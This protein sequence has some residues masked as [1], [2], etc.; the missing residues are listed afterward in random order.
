[1]SSERLRVEL[2]T[3]QHK[4][5]IGGMP[6]AYHVHGSGPVVLAHPGGPG[7]EWGYLRM[8][9]VEKF[10]T[11]VYVEPLGTGASGRLENPGDYGLQLDAS[12][13]EGLRIHLGIEKFAF[14]GHSYG[15]FVAL[16]YALAH[17]AHVSAL[18]LYDT[19]PTNGPDFDQDVGSNLQSFKDEPWFAE[20]TTAFQQLSRAQSDEELMA[21]FA[22]VL[23][24]YVA[25]WAE[26]R[27]EL[28][29]R[30]S[31]MRV[32][33]ERAFRRKGDAPA[34]PGTP[35]GRPAPHDSYD[36][37]ARLGEIKAPTLV[38]VG[39]KDFICSPKMAEVIHRGIA[40][41]RLAV[42]PDTSHFAH[43]ETPQ[44]YARTIREFLSN[45]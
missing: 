23:P 17:P 1:M 15:G 12:N 13:V 20:A 34:V 21:T 31:R 19:S 29:G 27:N 24:L 45:V 38:Q 4:A 28:E 30:I 16:T 36:V 43:I 35:A 22:R 14:L 2:P 33:L 18:I 10:A 7:G 26:R 6:I 39:A 9:E 37:R 11:V 32:C 3:G 8:P 42:F 41:S 40:G 5:V 44:E 25:N